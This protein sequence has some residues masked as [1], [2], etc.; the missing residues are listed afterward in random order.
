MEKYLIGLD[1]NDYFPKFLTMIKKAKHREQKGIDIDMFDEIIEPR[2]Q[3][4]EEDTD[5]NVEYIERDKPVEIHIEGKDDQ[6]Y[7]FKILEADTWPDAEQ[8]GLDSS[9]YRALQAALTKELV[10]IQGPPGTGKTFMAMKIAEILIKNKVRMGRSTPI[11]VVCLTNHALDQF[12][13]GM[14]AFTRKIVRI[15]GQSKQPELA[16]FNLK[17]LEMPHSDSMI[18]D[19]RY[20]LNSLHRQQDDVERCLYA[21]EKG[22][23][24]NEGFVLSDDEFQDAGIS[25]VDGRILGK[26]LSQFLD[27]KTGYVTFK[28]LLVDIHEW[29][30]KSLV[31]KDTNAEEAT[32]LKALKQDVKQIANYLYTELAILE[33]HFKS[34]E[35]SVRVTFKG[36]QVRHSMQEKLHY[37]FQNLATARNIFAKKRLKLIHR[38]EEVSSI[39][40]EL[41]HMERSKVLADQDVI[42]LTTTG[43]A[44]MHKVL[45]T[46][47]CEIGRKIF[48]KMPFMYTNFLCVYPA[49]KSLLKRLLRSWN[50]TLWPAQVKNASN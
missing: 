33:R 37:Y 48:F 20:E 24:S 19:Y 27:G 11:L 32:K 29:T 46:I 18:W 44:R 35:H 9:Q 40:E 45:S 28:Q 36:G 7:A 17:Y 10:V 3:D 30:Q 16:S 1:K 34:Y 22:L 14:M 25:L 47:G 23:T 21:V 13:M 50:R 2:L 38:V 4:N 39:L 43:A 49:F 8:L 6:H 31:R 41:Q 42:G 5:Y 26:R 15:G 12:L